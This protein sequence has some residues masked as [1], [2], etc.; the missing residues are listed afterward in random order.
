[1]L[2]I[3]FLALILALAHCT[4]AQQW[5]SGIESE[6]SVLFDLF[7]AKTTVVTPTATTTTTS[8]FG[9]CSS[10]CNFNTITCLR[11]YPN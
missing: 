8:D 2:G 5:L 1:M 10:R 11:C 6:L 9:H 7:E 4:A 3:K